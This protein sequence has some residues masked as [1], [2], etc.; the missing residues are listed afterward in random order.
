M[1]PT[2]SGPDVTTLVQKATTTLLNRTAS[3]SNEREA[4]ERRVERLA[5][6]QQ[7]FSEPVEVLRSLVDAFNDASD[8]GKLVMTERDSFSVEVRGSHK[9]SQLLLTARVIDD[10][11]T[12]HNGGIYRVIGV[13]RIDPMPS[14]SIELEALRDRESF[15]SFN[16]GYKVNQAS[17]K[18]GNWIAFRFEHNPLMARIGYPRWFA[19][20]L[21]ELPEQL[22]I[23][24]ALGPYQH[25]PRALDH[26]WFQLLLGHLL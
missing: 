24:N 23:L 2:A 3:Q 9:R 21:D 5:I 12:R 14:M 18:F 10:L 16:L 7:A 26:E 15:G 19:V 13:A 22:Q 6:L 25:Q 11:D 8:T 4:H 20:D 17:D 1:S